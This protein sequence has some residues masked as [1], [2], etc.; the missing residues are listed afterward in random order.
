M[1][2][3]G[4][5]K[6]GKKAAAPTRRKA[7]YTMDRYIY[8]V[9][10]QV[11]GQKQK[12]VGLSSK[13][14]NILLD[15]NSDFT[16]QICKEAVALAKVNGTETVTAQSVQTAVRLVLPGQL[17]SYG[18]SEG[19]KAVIN[20]ASTT[21]S[22]KTGLRPLHGNTVKLDEKSRKNKTTKVPSQSLR[23]PSFYFQ[24]RVA[25]SV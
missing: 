20:Y 19:R 1:P 11:H 4:S 10:K 7:K 16:Q 23:G 14:M 12:R 13:G 17:A 2:S 25:L 18:V 6:A 8:K 22:L 9:L 3:K 24:L 5:K 21:D 15:L